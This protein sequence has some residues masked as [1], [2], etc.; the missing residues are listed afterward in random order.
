VLQTVTLFPLGKMRKLAGW[1][2]ATTVS[3]PN[4]CPWM[5]FG[6]GILKTNTDLCK[7]QLVFSDKIFQTIPPRI[8]VLGFALAPLPAWGSVRSERMTGTV[9]HGTQARAPCAC[10]AG[11]CSPFTC[12]SEHKKALTTYNKRNGKS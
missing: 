12:S 3:F 5:S 4:F 10:V 2:N 1:L 8:R 11:A 9:H 6:F 7:V